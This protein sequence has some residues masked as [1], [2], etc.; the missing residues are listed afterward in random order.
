MVSVMTVVCNRE[1]DWPLLYS[2]LLAVN[3]VSILIIVTLS[4]TPLSYRLRPIDL[5]LIVLAAAGGATGALFISGIFRSRF[6]TDGMRLL[7]FS[8]IVLHAWALY[9]YE[10]GIFSAAKLRTIVSSLRW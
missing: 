9:R 8:M 1:L 7:L 6:R 5:S 4:R 2:Y 3:L 10:P